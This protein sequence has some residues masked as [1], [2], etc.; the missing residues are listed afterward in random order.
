MGLKEQLMADYKEAMKNHDSVKKETVNLVR[1]ALMA[2]SLVT[3]C[4]CWAKRFR[5]ILK[6]ISIIIIILFMALHIR[7]CIN[8][9]YMEIGSYRLT[10]CW[11]W[12]VGAFQSCCYIPFLR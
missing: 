4:L 8:G 7:Y 9:D 2:S 5:L 3:C 1:A 10:R 11:N 6:A 12:I